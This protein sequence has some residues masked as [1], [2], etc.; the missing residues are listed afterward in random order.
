MSGALERLR[1]RLAAATAEEPAVPVGA[2]PYTRFQSPLYTSRAPH[3]RSTGPGVVALDDEDVEDRKWSVAGW[4]S[5]F[6]LA[7]NMATLVCWALRVPI[8][9]LDSWLH[10]H[11][12]APSCS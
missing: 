5:C 10:A 12:L 7:S 4:L 3:P 1:A 11:G 9:G 2:T 8:P 6:L